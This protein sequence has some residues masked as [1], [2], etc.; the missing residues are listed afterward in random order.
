M[1]VSVHSSMTLILSCNN[2][3]SPDFK[4]EAACAAAV[5]TV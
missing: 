5:R 3:L 4:T 1:I 2:R